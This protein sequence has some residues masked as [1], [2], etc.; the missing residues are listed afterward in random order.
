MSG[1]RPR[2]LLV[3]AEPE[4]LVSGNNT[5]I[6]RFERRLRAAGLGA[7][8]LRIPSFP[9]EGPRL[10]AAR[11]ARPDVVHALHARHAG[12]EAVA[13][14]RALDRPLVVT[15][16]GTDLDQDVH[17]PARGAIVRA[18]LAAARVLLVTHPAAEATARAMG[19]P[20]LV[21]RVPKGAEPPPPA[22]PPDKARFGARADEVL[23]VLPAGVRPVKHNR[24]PV[25]PLA[26]LRAEGVP[27]RLLFA[28]PARD[29][30]YAAAL[31][32]DLASAPWATWPGTFTG[33]D[34]EVLYAS[35][36]VV[37]NVSH[38]EGGA[39]AVLEAMVRGACLLASSIPGNTV[40]L[41]ATA[42]APEAGAVYR[43][44][45]TADPGRRDHDP[46]DFLRLARELAGS[47]AR[48][49]ALAAAARAR[50]VAEHD[51]AAEVEGILA[52][53]RDAAR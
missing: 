25:A 9:D 1:A 12:P 30:A 32:A 47:P 18:T 42:T 7:T 43:A 53:Y 39:N 26:R 13:L 40:F 28:G 4:G 52:G 45:P 17:D 5:T 24:F 33:P 22:P 38:S 10:A 20:L 48:R 51:P 15:S 29:D 41:E 16:G 23:F 8:L 11:A 46:D 36:D 2:V 50:A 3:T 35:A 49:A 37:L 27:V 31:R 34:R 19:L 14:A 44:A 21:R 6:E